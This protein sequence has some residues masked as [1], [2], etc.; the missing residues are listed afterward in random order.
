[1]IYDIETIK[2]LNLNFP[3]IYFTPEYG[4]LIEITDNGKWKC[5]VYNNGEILIPFI[6]KNIKVNNKKI[7]HLISNYGYGG[8]YIEKRENLSTFL[9]QFEI[10]MATNN[11]I[12]HFMRFTP[13]FNINNCIELNNINNSVVY[14][15]TNTYGVNFTNKNYESYLKTTHK[16]HRKSLKKGLDYLYFK[17]R[18][19]NDTDTH[20]NSEFQEIYNETMKRVNSSDYYY[21]KKEY[22]EGML[23]YCKN[24]IF[25]AEVLT[26]KDNE[27]VAS[28]IIFHWNN[29][30]IH[31]H[32]GCSKTAQ[33]SL[34]PNNVLHDGIIQYGFNHKY[35]LYH[36]GGGLT[37]GDS[38]DKFKQ[39]FSNIKFDYNQC[40]IIYNLTEYNHLL[41]MSEKYNK[42]YFPEYING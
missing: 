39:Q 18:L 9:K 25:I 20:E 40:K 22:Y 7:I 6:E 29:K 14:K 8:I 16:N 5:I 31:Y 23:F 38:L 34:C 17:I 41:E 15:K 36:V 21:F 13:Y 27:V 24:N 32:L 33:L 11:Y 2:P 35:E 4:K 1:M 26:K 19:M 12:T 37:D 42:D 30:Y 10:V 3:D 28:A